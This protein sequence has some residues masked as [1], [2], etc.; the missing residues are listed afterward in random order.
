ML[1]DEQIA[2][3]GQRCQ[4]A[5]GE[6][7]RTVMHGMLLA[8]ANDCTALLGERREAQAI[9]TA[10]KAVAEQRAYDSAWQNDLAMDAHLDQYD[11]RDAETVRE[12]L[13]AA[14]DALCRAVEASDEHD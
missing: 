7:S 13:I 9:V 4:A 2:D 5:Q 6:P 3:I 1:T 10:A 14:V 8:I 11:Y 12:Q